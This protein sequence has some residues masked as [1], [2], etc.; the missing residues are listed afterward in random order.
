VN[1]GADSERK[2]EST[3]VMKIVLAALKGRFIK[4]QG[5]ALGE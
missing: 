5:S 4:A 3:G 2:E 1:E